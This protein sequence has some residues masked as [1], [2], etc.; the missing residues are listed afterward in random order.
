[1]NFG[2]VASI[3]KKG[4]SL[5]KRLEEL[6][7]VK[8]SEVAAKAK[9]LEALKTKLDQSESLLN[10]DAL[11]QLRRQFERA[12]VDFQRTSQD[13]QEEVQQLQQQLRDAFAADVLPIV[14]R[15]AAEKSLWAVFSEPDAGAIWKLPAL[16]LSDEIARRLDDTDLTASPRP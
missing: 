9:E 14:E 7:A 4:Q 11:G 8:S 1:M 15:V 5:S 6:S 2:R 16:D 3:S 10:D 12:Q 13:A